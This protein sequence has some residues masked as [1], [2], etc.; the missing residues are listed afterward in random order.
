MKK[1]IVTGGSG[2]IGSNLVKFLLKKKYFVINIDCL[3]YAAN[4]YN[5]E[6]LKK[7]KNYIF[8]KLDLNNKNKITKILKKHKPD[9]IFNLAA[10]THVD[11]SIDKPYNF[12]HSNILG[13]FSLL[14][15]ILAYKK[16]I[17]L[18]H[19]STDEV[20]GDIIKGRSDEKYPYN[21]SSP[22][23]SSKASADHL[24]KA[25]IRTY[26]IPAVIS[27]CCNNYGPNQFPEKLI[28]KL[29]FNIMNNRP[30]PIYGKGKNSREWMHVQDHCEALLLIFLKGKIGESYNI[31]TGI[32]LKNLDIANKLLKIA[33]NKYSKINGKTKI[34]FVK[35]R[36]CHY[37]RYSLNNRKIKKNWA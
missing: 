15:S 21:P 17:K 27:N 24:I 23:S 28:P 16:K 29:I 5:T 13:T 4:P 8:F 3:K 11:R 10:E 34:K 9:G 12:I 36:P 26:N 22:Y 35:D 25:Y 19:I 2:F 31:G 32:N 20:Y 6:N 33:K 18:V 30:L 7:N 1:I 14:E 37:I